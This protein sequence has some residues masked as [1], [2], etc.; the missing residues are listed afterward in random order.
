MSGSLR[1]SAVISGTGS[2]VPEQIVT[3]EDLSKVVDTNDDWITSRTGIQERRKAGNDQ[4]S[5]D[6]GTEAAK[7]A[8][9]DAGLAIGDIDGIIVATCTPDMI[10]P[11]TASIIQANLG[12]AHIFCFDLS[13]ACSGFLYALKVARDLVRSGTHE[14]ILV[15]G[16]EKM[17]SIIDWEDRTTCILFGDAAGAAVVSASDEP[18][19]GLLEEVHGADGNLG[20][21]LK[22]PA[23]GSR[24]PVDPSV[25]A[26]KMHCIKMQGRDVFKHAVNNMAQATLDVLDKQGI[27]ADDIDL[28][29]PHQANIRILNAVRDKLKQ[30]DEKMFHNVHKY[31]NTSAASIIVALDEA[32]KAGRIRRGDKILLAAFGAGFTWGTAIIQWTKE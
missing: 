25:L 31:G 15:I 18:E 7:L 24:M 16:T 32:S 11:N 26:D 13:A 3:N 21:L 27:T 30:P 1:R 20:D 29:I 28:F 4:A 9:E 2:Y 12:A 19:T 5:S 6:L 22:V 8:L 23:G 14:N 10:F 17:S